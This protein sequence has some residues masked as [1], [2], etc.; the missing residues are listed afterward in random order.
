VKFKTVSIAKRFKTSLK[1]TIFNA[2]C[3]HRDIQFKGG[4]V[5]NARKTVYFATKRHCNVS[6]VN[7]DITLISPLTSVS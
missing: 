4:D 7:Q 5:L 1:P 2:N 3:A 6:Y